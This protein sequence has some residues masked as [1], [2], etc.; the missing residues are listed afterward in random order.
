MT[1][2]VVT[3]ASR[4]IG[5]AITQDLASRGHQVVA[6]ARNRTALE[7]LAREVAGDVVPI[8]CDVSD[9]NAVN[10]AFAGLGDV[11]ILVNNAGAA[12]SNPVHRTTLTQWD[13]M[14]RVNAT[15][16]FLCT[17][18]VLRGMRQ[19]DHGRIVTIASVA[20]LSGG[21]YIAAYAASK[22]AAVGLIRVVAAEVRGSGVTANAVCPSY[23]RTAMTDNTVAAI[24]E[25]SGGAAGSG[26]AILVAQMGLGR[27]IEP[28]EVAAAVAYLLSPAAA[29]VNG[30]VIVID[31]GGGE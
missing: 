14:L 25:R 30:E 26:E 18:A 15:G 23:V 6:M 29:A 22:H 17:R 13:E 28:E 24:E 1:V 9:E 27:L 20:G 16:P 4:G 10:E 19:R 5:R 2:A 11:D 21:R 31:G 3:G 12:T 7:A 8:V